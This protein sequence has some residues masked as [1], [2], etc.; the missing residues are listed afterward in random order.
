MSSHSRDVELLYPYTLLFYFSFSA[1][2]VKP[3]RQIADS[4][5]LTSKYSSKN[6]NQ[7]HRQY[8]IIIN[9]SQSSTAAEAAMRW[10]DDTVTIRLGVTQQSAERYRRRHSRM[11]LRMRT[12]HFNGA[13]GRLRRITRPS[14]CSLRDKIHKPHPAARF[15]R[16]D[17]G[18]SRASSHLRRD[19][20]TC[21][22]KHTI[23]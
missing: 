5:P 11:P 12:V 4:T 2:I 19:W 8:V 17:D 7:R 15:R 1:N 20:Y 10:T 13:C 9:S 18:F 16:H 6:P 22:D 3:Q 14:R 23:H 21:S